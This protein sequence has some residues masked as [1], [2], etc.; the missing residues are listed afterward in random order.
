MFNL[1]AP[2]IEVEITSVKVAKSSMLFYS[3]TIYYCD[4]FSLA[5]HIFTSEVDCIVLF[6]NEMMLLYNYSAFL[7]SQKSCKCMTSYSIFEP[8]FPYVLFLLSRL[9]WWNLIRNFLS[10]KSFI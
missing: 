4:Q 3:I 1:I 8:L 2:E 5:R 9:R 6:S 7:F 10:F